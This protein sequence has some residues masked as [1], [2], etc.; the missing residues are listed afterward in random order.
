MQFALK[1]SVFDDPVYK[2][3]AN[4]VPFVEGSEQMLGGFISD[5]AW[6]WAL[7]LDMI[8]LNGTLM[9]CMKQTKTNKGK[10]V[11]NR[12]TGLPAEDNCQI[13]VKV[14]NGRTFLS[15]AFLT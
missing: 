12:E 14:M 10:D 1:Y 2:L 9:L 3:Q 5:F 6:I 11:C 8:P 7:K 4:Y 13:E 15:T